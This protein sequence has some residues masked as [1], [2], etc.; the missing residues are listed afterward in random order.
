M[1][2]LT[3]LPFYDNNSLFYISLVGGERNGLNVN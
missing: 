1:L 3:N 2:N